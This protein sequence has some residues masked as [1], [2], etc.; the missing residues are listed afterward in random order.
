MKVPDVI[1]AYIEAYNAIDVDAMLACLADDVHFQN[2]S[3]GNVDTETRG[4]AEFE[5]LARMGA[6]AFSAR[7]QSVTQT[8]TVAERTMIRIDYQATV[9]A[10]LPNGWKAGQSLAFS[11]A[12]YFEVRDGLIVRI[13][14]ES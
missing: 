5:K 14:D 1:A 7:R 4:K 13:I 10:D 3:A 8:I 2:I 6:G 9:A 11:G 12:S